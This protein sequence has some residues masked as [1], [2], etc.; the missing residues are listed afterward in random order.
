MRRIGITTTVPSEVIFASGAVPLD[1]NNVFITD[2]EPGKFVDYAEIAGYPRNL[3]GWIKGI[4]GVAIAKGIK[5]VVAVTQGDCSNTHALMETLFLKGVRIIPFA[6][7]YDRDREMLELQL[8]KMMN[9]L[10][11]AWDEVLYWQ[12]KLRKIREL[13]WELDRLTWETN[14]VTGFE[15]HLYQVSCSDFNGDPDSFAQEVRALLD[16]VKKRNSIK[17]EVR[18]GFMGVPPIFTDLYQYLEQIGARV[19]YN[20]IQRQFSMPFPNVDFIDQYLSYTYPYHAFARLED[21]Q[22]EI[23][24]RQLDGL[25]HYTQSFCFRQIED[26][27]YRDKLKMPI[28]TLEGDR[29]GPLDARSKMRIDAFVEMLR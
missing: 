16:E 17:E 14:Q 1:L 10:G 25:I 27:I 28:L 24:K 21:L 15:N 20:E 22:A 19:V 5:E 3:C 8:K 9:V 4:Y 26:L 18:L 2:A 23:T 13:V 11:V 29:P 7:P 12:E 6:F